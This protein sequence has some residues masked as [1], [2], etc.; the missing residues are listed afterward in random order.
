MSEC[1]KCGKNFEPQKG[2]K[3]YC[4]IACRNSR[5]W[6]DQ[7]KLKKSMSAKGSVKV[8]QA[9]KCRGT[10][11]VRQSTTP[12]VTSLCLHCGEA[13][14]HKQ[15][16]SRK[17]H[18]HCWKEL[19]GGYRK[20]SGRGR[21]GWYN[22]YWCDSSYELAW[23]IYNL[24]H[25]I[26]FERNRLKFEYVWNGN[27]HNYIPDFI[28]SNTFIEIKG[29]MTAQTQEKMKSVPN[30]KILFRKDLQKEFQYVEAKYGKNFTILYQQTKQK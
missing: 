17:Y 1:N 16:K 20:G 14:L 11:R 6:T 24:D 15:S 26:P 10:R 21:S 8:L 27:K 28:Q 18:S 25:N 13:I 9:N 19:S 29:F 5:T 12:M 30:L 3:Q 7:D 23:I 22:G 2:L 4:S